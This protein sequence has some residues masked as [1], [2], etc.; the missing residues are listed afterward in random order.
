MTS[1]NNLALLLSDTFKQMQQMMMAMTMPGQGSS[2]KSGQMPSQGVGEKQQNINKRLE[3]VGN[4]GM[5]GR[6]LS[7]E[8]AEIAQEQ[9]KLR[10][11]VSELQDKL[12]GT[13]EGAEI[14]KQLSE[15]EKE[16][17]KSEEDIVNKRIS[18]TLIKR[19]KQIEVR[20]L[21]A[22]KAIKKQDLDNK[23][24]SKTGNNF[25]LKSPKQIEEIIKQKN[26]VNEFIRT[27]PPTYTPFYKSKTNSYLNKIK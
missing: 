27:T 23:R 2:G 24:E 4:S 22:E 8:L 13:K 18:P 5:G 1:I 6:K 19:Q 26:A 21:E 14:G 12:N 16:M 17:N 9:A 15:L 7:E 10:R 20:L 25:D 11:E 3:G